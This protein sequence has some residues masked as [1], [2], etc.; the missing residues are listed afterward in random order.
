MEPHKNDSLIN[1]KSSSTACLPHALKCKSKVLKYS[2]LNNSTMGLNNGKDTEVS[3]GLVWITNI[4][5]VYSRMNYKVFI[6]LWFL[7]LL[8]RT[9]GLCYRHQRKS[10]RGGRCGGALGSHSCFTQNNSLLITSILGFLI[11]WREVPMKRKNGFIVALTI[12]VKIL[13]HKITKVL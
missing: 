7:K 9:H 5:T 12:T 6:G 8:H 1:L 10:E 13:Q 2:L 4:F 11:I 3:Y